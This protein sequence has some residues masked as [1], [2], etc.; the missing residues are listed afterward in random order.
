M[1]SNCNHGPR[2]SVALC[3][4]NGHRYIKDQILSILRQTR[5]P[6]ELVISDDGSSDGTIDIVRK[7]IRERYHAGYRMP[8]IKILEADVLL[9]HAS[10]LGVTRNFERAIAS[11]SSE[12]IVLS[13]QD[14]LW[15]P[16]KIAGHLSVLIGDGAPLLHGSDVRLIDEEGAV[17]SASLFRAM[18]VHRAISEPIGRPSFEWLL[19]HS[20]LPGMAI[21]F[22]RELLDWA[23]PIPDIWVHDRWLC[24]I[25]RAAGQVQIT[26]EPL[27]FY[28]QHPANTIGTERSFL[29][30]I[31]RR[32]LRPSAS[33]AE[34]AERFDVLCSRLRQVGAPDAA[35]DAASAKRSFEHRRCELPRRGFRRVPP[36]LDLVKSGSYRR[37]SRRGD[38]EAI[39]DLIL[40]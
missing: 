14:D 24:L 18:G 6:D 39:R 10:P 5:M 35:V 13:D 26:R 32:G 38:L 4:F 34:Y 2:V 21:A 17:V 37:W 20:I 9:G 11:T 12:I 23:L 27:A 30:R 33:A 25:A 29:T 19:G 31:R 16:A 40:R 28:R 15:S 22:R 1:N 7:T 36:V 3:C 8:A